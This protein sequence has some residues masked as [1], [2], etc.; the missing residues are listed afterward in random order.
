[1]DRPL[2]RFYAFLFVLVLLLFLI[3]FALSGVARNIQGRAAGFSPAVQSQSS[4]PQRCTLYCQSSYE[5]PLREHTLLVPD[6]MVVSPGTVSSLSVLFPPKGFEEARFSI[7]SGKDVCFVSNE[8]N[9]G[10]LFA[11]K[12]GYCRVK[13][14]I[15]VRGAS[16]KRL[17]MSLYSDV[18]VLES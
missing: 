12:Q 15:Y 10:V 8:G 4:P 18:S 16:S 9:A 6:R 1:M 13:A 11:K 14:D 3:N 17:Y 5:D 7:D 2:A